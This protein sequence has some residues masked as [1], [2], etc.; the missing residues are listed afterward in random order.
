MPQ[1]WILS[2]I[3]KCIFRKTRTNRI[4]VKQSSVFIVNFDAQC[5]Q[6]LRILVFNENFFYK[7]LIKKEYKNMM[8]LLTVIIILLL[9][10]RKS[11]Y[12]PQKPQ[13]LKVL[14]TI[15]F[16][17]FLENRSL[18]SG[19]FQFR[20]QKPQ[21]L[22]VLKTID[23]KHFLENKSSRQLSRKLPQ[24]SVFIMKQNSR[25]YALTSMVRESYREAT[26]CQ[27]CYQR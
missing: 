16:K 22:K 15:D 19:V 5:N 11:R 9:Y 2:S 21:K 17:D 20:L 3:V 23:F 24:N 25:S 14:K 1:K 27:R 18:K 4:L 7:N 12:G 10:Y 13:K 8:K 6:K 26:Q